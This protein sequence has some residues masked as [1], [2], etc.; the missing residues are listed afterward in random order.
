[1][2]G[3][4]GEGCDGEWL[5]LV[6]ERDDEDGDILATVSSY[7]HEYGRGIFFSSAG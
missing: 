7:L 4:R 3:E 2:R 5:R 6:K 1:M